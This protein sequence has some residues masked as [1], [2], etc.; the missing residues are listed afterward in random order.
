[1]KLRKR[2][3]KLDI[4]DGNAGVCAA[5]GKVTTIKAIATAL[6]VDVIIYAATTIANGTAMAQ[7]IIPYQNAQRII[8]T[9]GSTRLSPAADNS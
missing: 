1:M 9:V 6:N 7:P 8:V 3:V 2:H 4:V 5:T